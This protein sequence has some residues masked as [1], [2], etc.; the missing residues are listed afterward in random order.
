ML[1]ELVQLKDSTG[2]SGFSCLSHM[3]E[4]GSTCSFDLLLISLT[5]R[6]FVVWIVVNCGLCWMIVYTKEH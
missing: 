1:N 3:R 2:N 4:I 5:F 6:G